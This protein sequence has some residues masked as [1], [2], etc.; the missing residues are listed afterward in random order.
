MPKSLCR[1]AGR[2]ANR[3]ALCTSSF[4]NISARASATLSPGVRASCPPVLKK[5]GRDARA[6][7]ARHLTGARNAGQVTWPL[8][9]PLCHAA[10]ADTPRLPDQYSDIAVDAAHRQADAGGAGRKSTQHERDHDDIP[11]RPGPQPDGEIEAV[12]ASEQP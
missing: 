9:R 11:G 10:G 2:S 5:G 8:R 6:P 4:A 12:E 3:T 1:I 7:T